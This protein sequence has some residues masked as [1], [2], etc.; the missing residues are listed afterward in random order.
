MDNGQ[1]DGEM[2]RQTMDTWMDGW[3]DRRT[4]DRWIEGWTMGSTAG[5][6]AWRAQS[7]TSLGSA[8]QAHSRGTYIRQLADCICFHCDVVL[9]QFL[10]DFIDALR[11]I[12]CLRG[13]EI[14]KF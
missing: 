11:D 14:E 10:L 4:M 7:E 13:N 2:D 9:L 12:L 5:L 6:T 3:M 8:A 1:V